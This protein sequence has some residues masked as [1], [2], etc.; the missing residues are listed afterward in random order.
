M[1]ATQRREDTVVRF[2]TKEGACLKALFERLQRFRDCCLEFTAAG[3]F[4]NATTPSS[5]TMAILSLDR[6]D[7]YYCKTPMSMGIDI[8]SWF[9]LFKK[10]NRDDI[11]VVRIDKDGIDA[12]IPYASIFIYNSAKQV[13]VNN[14]VCFLDIMLEKYEIPDKVFD[15]VVSV[16]SIEFLKILRWCES[17]STSVRVYT[18]EQ[19]GRT[20]LVV[21]TVVADSNDACA[22]YVE[23]TINVTGKTT[24][25]NCH[26]VDSSNIYMLE[27][28]LD[29]ARSGSMNIGGNAILYLTKSEYPLVI[30][31]S[32]GTMGTIKYCLGPLQTPYTNQNANAKNVTV[33]INEHKGQLDENNDDDNEN[34]DDDAA[35]DM[36]DDGVAD[37]MDED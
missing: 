12:S 35:E 3:I 24:G 29:I 1:E 17:D 9:K 6:L 18:R 14:R 34:A 23:V 16:P 19:F 21:Q 36:L 8:Y 25:P 27:S 10:V 5:T 22:A 4:T 28:L 7:D 31:Y 37:C 2:E 30:D 20:H 26:N 13:L 32:V 33:D 15:A 11:V